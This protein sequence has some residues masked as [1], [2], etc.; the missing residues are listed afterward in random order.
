V[1]P[2]RSNV[3]TP[4][5]LVVATLLLS[6]VAIAQTMPADA[7]QVRYVANL[8][9]GDSFVNVTNA[10]TAGGYD[11]TAAQI[12]GGGPPGDIC[13][14][15][16]VFDPGQQMVAC[17]AC[18]LTPNHLA[19]LSVRNDLISNTLTPH[20]PNAVS[21]AMVSTLGT[22]CNAASVSLANLTSGLRAWTVTP[23][24]APSGFYGVT[25]TAF[26][27]APLSTSELT[28]LSSYC[29]FIQAL[30]SGYGICRSCRTGAQGADKQ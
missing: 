16:Y 10:G 14:N 18:P 1:H 21:I 29:G 12:F 23:H 8:N 7:L 24:M 5:Q 30:G 3:R 2:V 19:T 15:V 25:E 27:A 17:C 6:L 4:V 13:A 26:L 11:S 28:K 22:S 20:V 9:I